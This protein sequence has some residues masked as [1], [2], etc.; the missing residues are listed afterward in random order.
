[1]ILMG[2]AMGVKQ[3]G[4]GT[5][6]PLSQGDKLDPEAQLQESVYFAVSPH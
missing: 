2:M 4:D 5:F 3:P 6:L 1:M